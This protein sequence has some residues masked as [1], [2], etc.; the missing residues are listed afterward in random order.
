MTSSE[1][2]NTD[3]T[4]NVLIKTFRVM[5]EGYKKSKTVRAY[6][7]SK[8]LTSM[9]GGSTSTWKDRVYKIQNEYPEWMK[10]SE[11][12]FSE[13]VGLVISDTKL[14]VDNQKLRNK[15]RE[16]EL[17]NRELREQLINDESMMR[18]IREGLN[19]LPVVP[20]IPVQKTRVK[21]TSEEAVLMLSDHHINR[22]INPDETEGF[23]EYNFDIF[24]NRYWFLIHE[25]LKIIEANRTNKDIR[26]LHVDF[27]GDMFNDMHRHEN[28]RN[29]EFNPIQAA[30]MGGYVLSQGLAVLSPHFD[31]L[32]ITGV[33]GNEPRVDQ[34]K[35]SQQK[36]NNFDY[37]GY[38]IMSMCL[39]NY[40]KEKRIVFNIPR[41]PEIVLNRM[42]KNFLLTHGDQIR[43]WMGIPFYGVD[44]HIFKQQRKRRTRGGF[45]YI[46]MGHFHEGNKLR[47][48]LMNGALCGVDSYAY[49]D[50]SE[51]GPP[52]QKLFGL[53]SKY[54][55]GWM[56][57]INCSEAR[58]NGFVY[59][60]IMTAG[61]AMVDFFDKE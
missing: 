41:S 18:H 7:L 43:S 37:L 54:G 58:E 55:V 49:H 42:G 23:N 50:L 3:D 9:Y 11:K 60:K 59:S 51:T 24:A 38:H 61:N 15:I 44:R 27:L 19:V 36:Y 52:T 33:I 53:N 28:N 31:L 47:E 8:K 40:I 56:Y 34:K 2:S 29:N 39:V 5:K 10:M 26:V 32:N 12:E 17:H 48:A 13:A 16:L 22:V 35:P 25:V 14:A 21:R 4:V 46:E 6:V 57:D 45:D 30:I 20:K 1:H